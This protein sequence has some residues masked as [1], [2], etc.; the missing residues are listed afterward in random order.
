MFVAIVIKMVCYINIPYLLAQGEELAKGQS[1]GLLTKV[2]I[3][4]SFFIGLKE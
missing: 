1:H 4:A 2:Y 3:E